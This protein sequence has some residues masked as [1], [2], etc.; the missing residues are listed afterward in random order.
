MGETRQLKHSV[1]LGQ[2]QESIKTGKIEEDSLAAQFNFHLIPRQ[3]STP[4]SSQQLRFLGADDLATLGTT[5]L[6]LPSKYTF[7]WILT[8]TPYLI[9]F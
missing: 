5:F 6:L 3:R 1:S 4:A 8:A 7:C 9:A 2:L